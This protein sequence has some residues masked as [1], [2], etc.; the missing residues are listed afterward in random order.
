MR[1]RADWLRRVLTVPYVPTLGPVHPDALTADLFDEIIAASRTGHALPFDRDRRWSPRKRDIV[2]VD[3][4][5][6]RPTH[7]IIPTLSRRGTGIVKT[8]YYGGSPH[9]DQLAVA[10]RRWC[11]TYGAA[12]GRVIWFNRDLPATTGHCT[13]V[14]CKDFA[15]PTPQP[16]GSGHPTVRELESCPPPMRATF[17]EFADQLTDHGFGFLHQRY[18][19]GRVDGPILV[20]E[21]N[22]HIAGAIGPLDTLLDMQ[23]NRM[24]LPQYLGVA[25]HH[26]GHGHA[27]ALWRAAAT[28][29]ERHRAAYQMLQTRTGY[30]SDRLFLSE[31]LHS[32][33]FACS[34]AA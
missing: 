29:G 22:G 28:W 8:Y 15:R 14:L 16:P 33:G 18:Q 27:R 3:E 17:A 1:L 24:L 26:R 7:T 9:P 5:V 6:H 23:G 12:A 11:A 31:G 13:R 20:T 34:T 30:P 25:P 32:L 2:L 4:I 21:A 10:T 19:A